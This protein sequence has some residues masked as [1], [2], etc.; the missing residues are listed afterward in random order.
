ML[1]SSAHQLERKEERKADEDQAR[2]R[3]SFHQGQNGEHREP[4]LS[5][6]LNRGGC[7]ARLAYRGS[8]TPS[9]APSGDH[10]SDASGSCCPATRCSSVFVKRRWTKLCARA[11]ATRSAGAT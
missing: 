7:A 3:V 9:R 5:T 8:R 10:R 4:S 2:P 11:R 1:L 6:L